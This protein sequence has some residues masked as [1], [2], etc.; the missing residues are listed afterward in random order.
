VCE[1]EKESVCICMSA[2]AYIFVCVCVCVWVPMLFSGVIAEAEFAA[3]DYRIS[4]NLLPWECQSTV[5]ETYVCI[6]LCVCAYVCVRVCARVRACVC[7][8]VHW[9]VC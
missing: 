5:G 2:L 1:R 6:Q 3:L 7:A 8:S 9:S 4:R